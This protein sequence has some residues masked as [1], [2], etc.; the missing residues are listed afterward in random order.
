LKQHAEVMKALRALV[1]CDV[2]VHQAHEVA[3]EAVQRYRERAALATRLPTIERELANARRQEPKQA[4][5]HSQAEALGFVQAGE[6]APEAVD[7][8]LGDVEAERRNHE[9]KEHTA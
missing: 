4:K 6:P 9:D 1:D 5:A 7:R 2:I 8:L 3:L